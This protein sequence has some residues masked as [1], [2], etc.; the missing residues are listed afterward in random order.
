V[1]N[2]Y[3]NALL[4]AAVGLTQSACSITVED[5]LECVLPDGDKFLLIATADYSPLAAVVR[6][7]ARHPPSARVNQTQFKAFF[8]P[9]SGKRSES[10]VGGTQHDMNRLKTEAGRRAICA[11]FSLVN[12][13]YSI[14]GQVKIRRG[15]VL[16]ALAH[17]SPYITLSDPG[18]QEQKKR[19]DLFL[20]YEVG[21]VVKVGNQFVSESL[22]IQE[23][24]NQSGDMLDF[25]ISHVYQQV[26]ID[27]GKTWTDPIFTQNS[28]IAV[29]GKS[30][31]NQPGLAKPGNFH[32]APG[33]Q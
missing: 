16:E 24:G 17:E 5:S 22:F 4:L 14:D 11:R 9:K 13:Y 28:K 6:P 1:S 32:I 7:I 27:D 2:R 19:L 12:G 26:S 25:P 29:I 23:V 20:V 15:D 30:V 18:F 8:V 31:L 21:Y 3:A 10:S 33:I